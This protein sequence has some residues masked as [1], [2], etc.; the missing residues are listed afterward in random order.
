ML[1][2]G[3]R[4]STRLRSQLR[5]NARFRE[6]SAIIFRRCFQQSR[7]ETPVSVTIGF[8]S[9]SFHVFFAVTNQ[10]CRQQSDRRKETDLT[11]ILRPSALALAFVLTLGA[12]QAQTVRDSRINWK[13]LDDFAA[14]H[15]GLEGQ[16]LSILA[17][18]LGP[19]QALFLSVVAQFEQATGV[20]VNYAGSASFEQQILIETAAGSPPD[21]AVVPQPGLA[22]DLAAR[23]HLRDLGADAAQWVRDTYAAGDSWAA[24]GTYA[25]PDGTQRF[26]GFPYKAEV[27]SLVWYVPENLADAGYTVPQSYEDLKALTRWI[28]ADGQVPWC[29]GIGSGGATGWPA[30]DWV[31]DLMLRMYPPTVYDDW[32]TNRLP[33]DDPRVIAAIEEFGWFAADPDHVAGGAGAVAA[34]DFRD[35]ARG[36]FTSPPACYLHHQASFIPTFFPEDRLMGQ[37]YDFFYL[38]APADG[39]LGQPVLGSGTFF[40]VL[41]D[42]PAALAF[43]NFLKTP[44]AHELWMSQSGFTTPHLGVSMDAYA[45]ETQ[46]KL[47]RILLDASSFHFD[48][49]DLMPGAIGTGAFWTG[50]VD[51]V[52]GTPARQVAARVQ[53]SWAALN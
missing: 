47:G 44:A 31:E 26:Y 39:S 52:S 16:D 48:G 3:R 24:L 42:N 6:F 9:A 18:W 29:I 7:G 43:I 21:I 4:D 5:E 22:A 36:L 23:G 32:T 28:A 11:L 46:R 12:A 8:V 25:G 41:T 15:G 50:M 40:A 17:T 45:N 19:D 34:T 38:P 20:R 1:D 33:F 35:S 49:S 14:A 30:T 10:H 53:Q 2:D 37:D 51:F 27:K 13:S